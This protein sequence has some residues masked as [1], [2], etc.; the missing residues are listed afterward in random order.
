[1]VHITNLTILGKKRI[2]FLF[3]DHSEKTI[4]FNSFIREDALSKPLSDDAFFKKVE[5]YEKGRGI[6][7]PNGYDFCPDF[8]RK[9]E[10]EGVKV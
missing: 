3:S 4:D 10:G 9:Y 2:H 7:W 5:L 8:L 1:M 6:Y